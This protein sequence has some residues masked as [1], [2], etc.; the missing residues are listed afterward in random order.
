MLAVAAAAVLAACGSSTSSTGSSASKTGSSASNT[1]RT[2]LTTELSAQL[3]TAGVPSDLATCVTLQSRGLPL[4]SVR[5]LVRAGSDAPAATDRTG[6]RVFATCVAQGAGVAPLRAAMVQ[7]IRQ[8]MPSTL[9]APFTTCIEQ[10]AN[11]V[12]PSEL[13]SLLFG[14]SATQSGSAQT[15]GRQFGVRIAKQCVREPAMRSVLLG[16]LLRPVER[17]LNAG[18]YSTAFKSCLLGKVRRIPW[19]GLLR[20]VM[21]GRA[22]AERSFGVQFGRKA[23]EACVAS[24]AKP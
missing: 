14:A 22:S 24:G 15:R 18:H 21:S 20:V 9:P 1:E 13:A 7:K 16:V 8:D 2:R 19:S 4:G 17:G 3:K 10:K 23:A 12:R 6:N 11:A 5:E